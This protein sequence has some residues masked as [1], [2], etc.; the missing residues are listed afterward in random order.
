M[1]VHRYGC[2]ACDDI[3]HRQLSR[4]TTGC[5]APS[6]CMTVVLSELSVCKLTG[7]PDPAGVKSEHLVSP[8]HATY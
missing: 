8:W 1:P 5:C 2:G 4:N 6:L 7:H 3:G